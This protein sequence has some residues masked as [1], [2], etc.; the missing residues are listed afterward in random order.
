MKIL[1][2]LLV[3]TV[4]ILIATYLIPGTVITIT[5]AVVLAIVLGIINVFIK[6]VVKLITLPLTIV[7]LGIFS[8]V[9]NALFILL[10]AAIVPGFSIAG[11]WTAFWFSIVLSLINAFFNLFQDKAEM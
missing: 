11:F 6:P 8:L 5:G 4:A 2:H 10:A 3:S 9:I 1:I 7:T